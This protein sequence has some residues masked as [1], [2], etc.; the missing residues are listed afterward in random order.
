MIQAFYSPTECAV[1]PSLVICRGQCEDQRCQE[2]H[3]W[4]ILG[5]FLWWGFMITWGADA[6]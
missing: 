2:F 1:L 5:Q 3:G 6:P 4:M